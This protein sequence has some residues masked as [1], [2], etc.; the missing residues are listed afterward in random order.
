MLKTEVTAKSKML[1]TTYYKNKLYNPKGTN[2]HCNKLPESVEAR[3]NSCIILGR[4]P[5]L[6][7]GWR[8]AI[9]TKILCGFLQ[10][11]HTKTRNV[12]YNRS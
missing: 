12:S 6:I 4:S 3:T 11:L 10:S 5:F 1:V 2:P 9:L 8:T 7:S